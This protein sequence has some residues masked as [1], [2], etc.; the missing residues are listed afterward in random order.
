MGA[1]LAKSFIFTVVCMV[2]CGSVVVLVRAQLSPSFYAES[3]PNLELIVRSAM[4]QAVAKDATLG[5][6]M[7]RLFFH[8]CF[9][10]G[11]DASV[12]LD[13]TPSIAGEK[14][15]PPNR[16]SLRG[17]V[18]VDSIKL[19][20]ELQCRATVSCAD[21]LA[22]AARDGVNLLGGP[23]WVVALGRRD[24]LT[25]SSSA[26]M[27]NLPPPTAG[28]STLAST[29]ASKG[30][31]MR[32]MTVLSGAHT[33]GNARCSSFRGHIYNDTNIDAGFANRRRLGCQRVG[34]DDSLAPLD[35]TTSTRFDNGYFQNLIGRRGLL[36]SDQ[37]MFNDGPADWLVRLYVNDP[38]AFATDFAAAMVKMGNIT[39]L[40]GD[41]GEI[42]LNCR[43]IN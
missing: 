4:T 17:F 5:A 34:G 30:L 13:D 33:V 21:I 11:C 27:S 8:D 24:A 18:L 6:S 15:A 22:I 37:E 12:L 7:L 40:T 23:S 9:V 26:A 31:S 39:Q 16:N 25:A 38:V 42:R 20:V 32:D 14:N 35:A 19:Q 10:N 43:R 3:C 29:F 28:L 2:A 36:H 1:H 41:M